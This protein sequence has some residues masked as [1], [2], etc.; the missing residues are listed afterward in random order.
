[1]K[2]NFNKSLTFAGALIF[3]VSSFSPVWADDTEIYFGSTKSVGSSN[4][5]FVLDT[6]G[7]MS[8]DDDGNGTSRMD[9]MK[10]AFREVINSVDNVN[11]G[12]M[13]FSAPGGPIMFPIRPVNQALTTAEI[14][15]VIT[16]TITPAATSDGFQFTSGYGINN[17]LLGTN[18]LPMGTDIS[19]QA[20]ATSHSFTATVASGADDA[21]T[22]IATTSVTTTGNSDLYFPMRSATA[23]K[24]VVG[25]RF[26]S[27]TTVMP[28]RAGITS[29]TLDLVSL[30]AGTGTTPFPIPMKI[31]GERV[32]IGTFSTTTSQ[33]PLARYNAAVAVA[34]PVILDWSL[35][36]ATGA[37]QAIPSVDV[38][39][40][41]Q[42]MVNGSGWNASSKAVTL[43]ARRDPAASDSPTATARQ[44]V[45]SYETSSSNRPKL[46]VTWT[47]PID[48]G[49]VYTALRFDNVKIPRGA[50]VSSASIKF[51][52][53]ASDTTPTNLRIYA[54]ASSTPTALATTSGNLNAS[55]RSRTAAPVSWTSVPSWTA[56]EQ[57]DTPDIHSIVQDIV[58]RSDWCGGN[59]IT[60]LVEAD[61][62]RRI[63]KAAEQGVLYAPQLILQWSPSSVPVGSSCQNVAYTRQIVNST[64][65]AEDRESNMSIAG[66]PLDLVGES[67][68]AQQVGLRFTNVQ[69]PQNATITSAYLQFTAKNGD[70]SAL[71]LTINGQASDNPPTFTAINDNINNRTL[72]TASTSWPSVA[73][74]VAETQY[75][76]PAITTIVQELVNRGGWAQ[77][78]S[79]AFVIKGTSTTARRRAYSFDGSTAKAPR[80]IINFQDNGTYESVRRVRDE[81]IDVVDGFKPSGTTPSQDTLYEA[82]LYFM[83]RPVDYG[84]KR[85]DNYAYTRVSHPDSYTG[86]TVYTPPGC[87]DANPY[88]AAC[89]TEEI[90][91]SPVYK[92]PITASCQNNYIVFLT[93]G[94]PNGAVS[95]TKVK[96]LLTELTGN[97]TCADTGDKACVAEMLKALRE[98]DVSSTFTDAQHVY[99]STIGLYEGGGTWLKKLAS[100]DK[101]GGGIY[102]EATNAASI[103]EGFKAALLTPLNTSPTFVAAGT[104]VNA[105][106]RTLN[107]DELYF[108]MFKP[109]SKPRWAGNVKKYK[110]G[111]P[112][113]LDII[114]SNNLS[115]V[116]NGEFKAGAKSF[117]SDVTDGANV[118]LGG[119]A[120][121][122]TNHTSR[123][124]YTYLSDIASPS[125][126]LTASQNNVAVANAN[127]T[128]AM[129]GSSVVSATDREEVIRWTRGE[130]VRDQDG[131]GDL[132]DTRF[133]FADP[134]HS[135]P[136]TVTYGGS[137]AN[138]DIT[139]FASTNSGFLH[140]ID[141]DDG[142]ELFSFIPQE[143]LPLQKTLLE[144]VE[145]LK[146]PSGLDGS[147]TTMIID[148]DGDGKVLDGSTIQAN[149]QVLLFVGMRRGG[150]NYYALDVTNRSSPKIQ[151]VIKGGSTTGF[152]GLGQTWSQPVKAQI[153]VDGT[154]TDVLIFGGGY[155][156]AEDQDNAATRH[157]DGM[158]NAIFIVNAHDG[159]L[160]WSGGP[161]AVDSTTAFSAMRYGIPSTV[162]GADIDGDGLMDFFFV[163]D[164]G[165][166]LWRFDI[167]N[168]NAASSLV[169]GGVIA[170]IAADNSTKDTRRFYH[171]P[172]L[173]LGKN[174]STPYLGVAI[175]S[176]WRAHPLDD[177][178]DDRFYMIRQADIFS[179]PTSYTTLHESDLYDATANT[180]GEGTAAQVVSARAALANA[181]GWYIKL[182]N[183]GEKVLS[184]PLIASGNVY[185]NTY[186]PNAS[187]VAAASCQPTVGTNRSYIMSVFDATATVELNGAEG[188]TAGDRS[189]EV[190]NPG[191]ISEQPV[192]N[193]LGETGDIE[194]IRCE[195]TACNQ[196][197]DDLTKK[198]HRVY[199]YEKK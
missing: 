179:A 50:T 188:L 80:L 37:G 128:A 182:P 191:I 57:Y 40:I 13:R 84:K 9:D 63:A 194:R 101:G 54:E 115:A 45:R 23:D 99:T 47:D 60:I 173:F 52:A 147:I 90:M 4:V 158:G 61:V 32:D 88:A 68:Y 183:Q 106:N 10:A 113:S 87:T 28:A 56:G 95:T 185:F 160:I 148:P 199:W 64:D 122:I 98:K 159:S 170:D 103:A 62:G 161:N 181:G 135:R 5:L 8:G 31:V 27:G 130:D 15:S 153:N 171:P 116:A 3:T 67:N 177:Q 29:A 55:V 127:L 85:G 100:S 174:G 167:K 83:G 155:D 124:V 78:N 74:W 141:N 2:T 195:G 48:T 39:Q 125:K 176:G 192:I 168:G 53:D 163:G 156:Q 123:K 152:T 30:A 157:L 172:A 66:D 193:R 19:Y 69:I 178:V 129:F 51:T 16:Q 149:N 1:M 138:P 44:R 132:T 197:P 93:D 154:K 136:V 134:L 70:S 43:L 198:V 187:A 118:A 91:G 59:S 49:A 126:A 120:G 121:K 7:S 189:Q 146:H 180:I 33:T 186:E 184:A 12:L 142:E 190:L 89:A 143:L 18:Y 175:G 169:T 112:P 150:R 17:V 140:A 79:M 24:Q 162:S 22:T 71:S 145:G 26:S 119:A 6:S 72:T 38:R 166:Q 20:S 35:A 117:W 196:L 96:T 108:A 151:W 105:F 139:V 102:A 137:E 144:N 92:S 34:S 14:P 46:N 164:M 114:D 97:D 131:D 65:D 21:E 25:I 81:L 42:D 75:T 94:E 77:G 58:S 36:A 11:V 107:R 73:T 133:V 109:D 165:G 41:V 111:A 110:L 82:A 104:S 76:T 86:G